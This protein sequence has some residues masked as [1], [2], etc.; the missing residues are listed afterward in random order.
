MACPVL[1]VVDSCWEVDIVSYVA[2]WIGDVV[3][4]FGRAGMER[5]RKPV[6]LGDIEALPGGVIVLW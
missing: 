3:G 1:V 2:G 4:M 6:F 5:G